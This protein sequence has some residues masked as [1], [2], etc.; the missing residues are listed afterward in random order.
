MPRY[1]R[2]LP[3]FEQVEILDAGS[4]GNSVARVGDL[5]VFVPFTAPGDVVDIQVTR[6]KRSFCEG[7][8]IRF[9]QYSVKRAE[10]FCEHFGTCGGCKWQHL[11]YEDQLYYKQKQVEDNLARIGNIEHPAVLPIL[12]SAEE[13]YYRNKLEFTFSNHRWL[14]KADS[15]G[16]FPENEMSA[17]GFHIPRLFDKILDIHHCYLQPDPSDAIRLFSGNYARKHGIS[18]YDVRKWTGFLRNLIIRNTTT[19]DL[20]VILVVREEKDDVIN[21]MLNEMIAD[22]P[23]ITSVFYVVNPKQNDIINDLTL[24]HFYGKPFM[25]ERM[26]A[27]KPGCRDIEFRIGPISFFQTNSR[28][29]VRLYQAT[30]EFAMFSGG[31]TVY[32]LYTGTGTIANYIAPLVKKVAG[33]ESNVAAIDDARVNAKLNGHNNIEFFAGETEKLLTPEFIIENGQPEIVITDPP[34]SGMHEKVIRSLLAVSPEKIVYVSC[35]P[36]TQARDISLLTERYTLIKCQPVDMFPHTQHVENV[37][38]LKRR[39]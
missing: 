34:R 29:A 25:T 7:K 12:R 13:T 18:F 15:P 39:D 6:K 23:Q 24:H 33:I 3:V 14:T 19:G 16:Q 37:A 32:D 30:V 35:N 28:Q 9:H 21:G 8:A 22:F 26:P 31:E 2:T 1:N 20:L 4:E 38:L 5:V 27:F 10:P 11:R 36:A 17:L